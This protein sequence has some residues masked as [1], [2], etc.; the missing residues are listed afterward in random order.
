MNWM[1]SQIETR[2]RLDSQMTD[3]AYAELAE[4]VTAAHASHAALQDDVALVDGAARACL[5]YCGVEPGNVPDDVTDMQQRL[6]YL[7]RPSGTMW[8]RVCLDGQWYKNA[9]GP[10]LAQLDT[11]ETVALLPKKLG[12]YS[13]VDPTTDE[14]VRVGKSTAARI[15]PDA[16]YFYRPLPARPLKVRDLLKFIFMVFDVHDYLLVFAAAMAATIMGM[17]PAWANQV[18]FSVVVPSGQEELIAPIAMLL[19]GVSV[20]TVLIG[21][22][23]NL[24]TDRLVMKIDIVA[25][26][27]AFARML[28]LPTSFFKDRSGGE[29]GERVSQVSLMVQN[30]ASMLLGAGLTTFLSFAYIVQI[31]VYAPSL[32]VPAL[33]V[34]FVQIAFAFVTMFVT[35]YYDVQTIEKQ[36][37]LSGTVTA[38][39]NGMQKIKLSGAE[40]RAFAKWAHGYAGYARSLYNR[41][42]LVRVLPAI[43]SL[44]GMLGTI[45]IY[46]IAGS[47]AVAVAD[48]MSFNVA[49]GGLMAGVTMLM[50]MIDP[51]AQLGPM[52]N[53]VR[54]LLETAPEVVDGKPSVSSL[55]GGIEVSGVSFRYGPEEPYILRDLSFRVKPGEYVGIVGRSGCGKS[56]IIRL[57][58]GFEV[59]ERGTIMFGPYDSSKVDAGSLRR[60][61][62]VVTQNGKLFMGDIASNITIASPMATLDDAWEAAE[63]A[64]IADDIRQMP[65][66]M[67]TIVTEGGGGISGGQRQRIMIARAICGKRRILLFDEATSALD[68]MA[69]RHVS[70]SLDTLNCTRLVVA[71]RL[72]TVRHCD[73]IMVVDGGCIAEEGTFDEL[74]ARGGLFAELVARQ[75]LGEE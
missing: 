49:Y 15:L 68:N 29:L 27:A 56:T 48:Y 31:G 24:V 3:R 69:Q 25:E 1:E 74:I 5:R 62:G 2:A 65:M 73:R 18:V 14:R 19:L 72:S 75:R 59:P 22:C 30:L 33:V 58:M 50:G 46:A 71:H 39:L 12:G 21:I 40:D 34:L 10:L 32:A 54:P 67:Q 16:M 42:M 20:S 9:F 66:G 4:S 35:S 43:G 37:K 63:L 7:C 45:A 41:P 57:L 64:G 47:T 70:D 51:I 55:S 36:T 53:V 11:G 61:M 28:S 17:L 23:R 52:L 13:F 44:I 26:A 8:R 60:N 38:L 6:E